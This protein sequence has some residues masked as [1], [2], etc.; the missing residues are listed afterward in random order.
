MTPAERLE[1]LAKRF[2]SYGDW[3]AADELRSIKLPGR[4][5]IERVN[6]GTPR[7][8]RLLDLQQRIIDADGE[9]ELFMDD[10]LIPSTHK[11]ED[12]RLNFL[13]RIYTLEDRPDLRRAKKAR[14]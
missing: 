13:Q 12:E 6:G 10:P 8:I 5:R 2:E 7:Q 14:G 9:L 4:P 1:Q 11:T 3:A